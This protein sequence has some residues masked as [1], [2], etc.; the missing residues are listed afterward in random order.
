MTVGLAFS[1]ADRVL[2]TVAHPDDESLSAGGLLQRAAAV[3]C[4]VRVAFLTSGEDNPWAQRVNERKFRIRAEDRARFGHRREGEVLAA[5]DA[6]GVE[7]TCAVFLRFADQGTTGAMLYGDH[8]P[9]AAVETQLREFE[10]TV[11][12]GPSIADLHPDHSA[13]AVMLRLAVARTRLP[14][15]PPRLLEAVVHNPALRGVGEQTARLQLSSAERAR[16]LEAILCHR[17]QMAWRRRWLRSFAAAAEQ[18]LD[19][20]VPAVQP[21]PVSVDGVEGE[22]LV[23][24]LRSRPLARAWGRRRLHFLG[25]GPAGEIRSLCMPVPDIPARAVVS[26]LPSGAT[27]GEARFRGF[28]GQGTLELTSREITGWR[29]GFV[30]LERHFGFFDEAGWR[31]LPISAT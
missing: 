11:L 1:S 7:R 13:L 22:N 23:L 21:H 3:G 17:T 29:V 4:A 8:R 30:K 18:F 27:A 25:L 24:R 19:P 2:V 12:V 14:S 26:H 15:G 20:E 10:P 16:K 6:L 28:A 5:L 31:P 9:L